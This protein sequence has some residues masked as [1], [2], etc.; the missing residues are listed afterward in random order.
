VHIRFHQGDY[1]KIISF[2]FGV[3]W[4]HCGAFIIPSGIERGK[5]VMILEGRSGMR[6]GLGFI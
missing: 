2:P 1:D 6:D 3:W 4:D 5:E